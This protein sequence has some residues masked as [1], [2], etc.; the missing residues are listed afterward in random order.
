[1]SAVRSQYFSWIEG[2]NEKSFALAD[3]SLTLMGFEIWGADP[4]M[5]VASLTDLERQQ[6]VWFSS[7]HLLV[8]Q[9]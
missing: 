9:I 3:I 8:L 7:R 2:S 6:E 4:A 1:V 5:I